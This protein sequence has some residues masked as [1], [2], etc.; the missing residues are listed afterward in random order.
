[1]GFLGIA[2]A[3]FESDGEVELGIGFGWI[4]C[5]VGGHQLGCV[6]SGADNFILKFPA[7]NDSR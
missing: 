7:L 5:F 3:V 4:V 2:E 1:V 6:I